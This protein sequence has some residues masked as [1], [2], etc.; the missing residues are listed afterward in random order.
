MIDKVLNPPIFRL[1]TFQNNLQFCFYF[2]QKLSKAIPLN[3]LP[4][5]NFSTLHFFYT[6]KRIVFCHG[7]IYTYSMHSFILLNLQLPTTQS[8]N[9]KMLTKLFIVLVQV[10]RQQY[11]IFHW[12][13]YV[14]Y[15]NSTELH[16]VE[17]MWKR[18]ISVFPQIFWYF[19]LLCLIYVTTNHMTM[20]F[21]GI[22][23]FILLL[24]ANFK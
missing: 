11:I 12:V 6:F 19:M 22:Q 2:F 20:L 4:Q 15:R 17:I 9:Q 10:P 18:T 21:L 3:L 24:M 14:K 23:L 16:G 7:F 8:D 5:I 1:V 13:H